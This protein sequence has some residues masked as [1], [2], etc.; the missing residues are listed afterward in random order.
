MIYFGIVHKDKG[1]A[2]GVTFPDLPGCFSAAD[3][4]DNVLPEARVALSLYAGG[5]INLPASRSVEDL[6]K[7]AEIRLALAAGAFLIAVPL[8]VSEKKVRTNVML[9]RS[10]LEAIDGQ[11]RS[12]GVSRSEYLAQAARRK[13]E[14]DGAVVLER[15]E[16]G[17]MRAPA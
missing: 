3:E 7:D 14:S 15:D 6:T 13:L 16:A 11:A 12:I 2:Y 9:D 1:S 4:I 5:E 8:V 17:R 10:L